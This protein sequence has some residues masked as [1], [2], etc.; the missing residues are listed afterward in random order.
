MRLPRVSQE[1]ESVQ[2][3]RC[4]TKGEVRLTRISIE[5][6]TYFFPSGFLDKLQIFEDTLCGKLHDFSAFSDRH[7]II[8]NTFAVRQI[9]SG[10][11]ARSRDG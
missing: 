2:L 8:Q 11:S 3:G 6:T 10:F 7:E 9:F 1:Y 4:S 5:V